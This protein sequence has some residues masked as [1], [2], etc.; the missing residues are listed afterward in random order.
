MIKYLYYDIENEDIYIEVENQKKFRSLIFTEDKVNGFSLIGEDSGTKNTEKISDTLF[1]SNEESKLI[2]DIL[3][4]DDLIEQ[5]EIRRSK[6]STSHR[7]NLL[8]KDLIV[9]NIIRLRL[10]PYDIKKYPKVYKLNEIHCCN[11][12]FQILPLL[13]EDVLLSQDKDNYNWNITERRRARERSRMRV[14]IR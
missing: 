3:L 8:N 14:S 11:S 12:I 2:F 5:F 13:G 7:S 10:M 6:E 9:E 4:K 1:K